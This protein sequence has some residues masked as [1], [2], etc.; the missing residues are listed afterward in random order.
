[1]DLEV[2]NILDQLKK[3]GLEEDTI[4]FFFSDHGSGMPRHKRALLE[5]GMHVPLLIHIPEK[6]KKFA[7]QKPGSV[8][9]QL[10]AF[11]DFAPTVLTLAGATIPK[12]MQGIPF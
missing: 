2:G 3:D 12:Y 10:V 8:C 6:W 1:M 7:T 11:V 5:S 4:V 9:D